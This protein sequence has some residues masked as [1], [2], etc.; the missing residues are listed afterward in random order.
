MI[1]TSAVGVQL[2]S[3]KSGLRIVR[4]YQ[5]SLTHTYYPFSEVPSQVT[6]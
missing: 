3:D 2:G 1:T 5:D 4:I 6:L